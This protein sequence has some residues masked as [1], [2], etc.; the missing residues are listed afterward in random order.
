MS[1]VLLA[2]AACSPLRAPA[3]AEPLR[4]VILSDL[5]SSYGSASYE[6]DV[7]RAVTLTV[8]RFRPQLVLI[9]GDMIAGQ[10]PTLT[11]S[12]VHTM[13]SVF[14]TTVFLPLRR[15]G[16]A[17]AFTV[18]NHDASGY[19]AHERDRRAALAHWTPRRDALGVRIVDAATFPFNYALRYRD[20]FVAVLDASTG[21]V[22]EDSA[23]LAWLRRTLDSDAARTA[24][25]RLTLGHV[26]LYAVAEGRNAPG[27]VQSQPDSVRALLEA[28]GVRMHISG[29][30][31]AYYPGRRGALELLHAGAL[32][33][34][35][36][37]LLGTSD[38][39]RTLTVLDF[40]PGDSIADS[41]WRLTAGGIE[42]IDPRTL[43]ARIDGINGWVLRRDTR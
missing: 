30:H 28:G 25:Q 11:D 29:H 39:Y 33:Q 10:R 41:T 14:D 6:P 36:R 42:P 40:L 23:Q 22:G 1:C 38:A 13:W 18:G 3:T 16:I 34:G 5:N 7:L 24:R 4:V 15:A 17:V 35:P 9:A 26:P 32:G 31:H 2:L 37:P 8:Q 27:E 19:P 20:L 12:T 21:R 43:P